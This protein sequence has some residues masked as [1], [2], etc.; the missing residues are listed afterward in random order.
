MLVFSWIIGHVNC[1]YTDDTAYKIRKPGEH[2]LD[3][4]E[5]DHAS[6]GCRI[7]TSAYQAKVNLQSLQGPSLAA[8]LRPSIRE[9]G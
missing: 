2:K 8:Q 9:D 3:R 5:Y 1:R 7:L 6:C 4:G